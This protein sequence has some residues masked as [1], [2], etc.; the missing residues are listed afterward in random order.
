MTNL[1][2]RHTCAC[3]Y[4]D[5]YKIWEKK[6]KIAESDTKLANTTQGNIPLVLLF[7]WSETISVFAGQK[8]T[9]LPLVKL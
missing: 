6:I 1:K 4:I 8:S 9:P 7:H 5:I 2:H 3:A